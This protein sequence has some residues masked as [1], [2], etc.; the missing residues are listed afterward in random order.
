VFVVGG[1]SAIEAQPSVV[2]FGGFEINKTQKFKL[3]RSS[4]KRTWA[5]NSISSDSSLTHQ[6]HLS[7]DQSPFRFWFFFFLFVTFCGQF[8]GSQF[9]KNYIVAET[10]KQRG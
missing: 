3:V 10:V 6:A 1:N 4:L 8:L 2:H 7:T 5:Q 9:P